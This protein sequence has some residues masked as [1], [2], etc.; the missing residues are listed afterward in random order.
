MTRGRAERPSRPWLGIYAVEL[1]GKVYVSGVADGGPAQ[2]ADLREGDLISQV[3]DTDAGTLGDFY[4]RIWS[5]G[6]AGVEIPL[7]AIRGG[8]RLHFTLRS[9]D[10]TDLL[11]RPQAN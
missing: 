2:L 1:S 5:L 9:M 3:G 10:R 8:T 7:T 11:I 4:R 6:A